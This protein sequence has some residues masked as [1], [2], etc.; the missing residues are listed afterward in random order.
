M[1]VKP[2]EICEI[3]GSEQV[4]VKRI[5]KPLHYH[6]ANP[7]RGRFP[8]F[9]GLAGQQPMRGTRGSQRFGV[10]QKV[11]R[12][13]PHLFTPNIGPASDCHR[14]QGLTEQRMEVR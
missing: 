3:M 12:N 2:A 8:R 1:L 5:T 11:A 7:A 10:S 6:C 9:S 4:S 13:T 14:E